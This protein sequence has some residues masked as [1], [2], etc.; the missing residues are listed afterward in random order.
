M[1]RGGEEG[2]EGVVRGG[3]HC[4]RAKNTL[5]SMAYFTFPSLFCV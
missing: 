4:S 3:G 1:R 5:I 2:Y